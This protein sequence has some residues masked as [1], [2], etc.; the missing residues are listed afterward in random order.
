M[1]GAL[2]KKIKTALDET[3]LLILG[4]QILVGFHLNGTFQNGFPQLAP[5]SRDLHAFA[6]LNMVCV[7]GLLISPSMQHRIVE[8]GHASTRILRATSRFA[9]WA[10]LPFAVA[11]GVDLYVV[12]DH[13]FGAAWGIGLGAGLGV[14]A[15]LF[16]YVAEWLLRP[17]AR[18]EDPM[19]YD[20]ETPLD[21]RVE[22][23]LTEARV[24]IPGAQ[25]L[26]GFQLAVLLTDAFGRLPASSKAAHTAALCCIALAVILLMAPAAF[27]RITFGGQDSEEFH[28][29]GSGLIMA[30]AVPLAAGITGDFYVAVAKALASEPIALALAA[31]AAATLIGLWFA[32]PLALRAKRRRGAHPGRR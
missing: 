19:P 7:V 6:F 29:L 12:V 22:H 28:R 23:M 17:A 1:S 26:F 20:E 15:L 4:A 5:A 30:S 24:L 21:V 25:A 32:Y 18:K 9:D 14:L 11:L 2:G 16:W 10:L 8:G 3:R 13:R 31:L 27:H